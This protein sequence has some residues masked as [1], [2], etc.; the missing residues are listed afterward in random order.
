MA[1]GAAADVEHRA[2]RHSEIAV[3]R[4]PHHLAHG[5]V[6]KDELVEPR[7]VV[8]QASEVGGHARARP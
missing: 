1:P 8:E 2:W 5:V 7:L 6:G 4:A 3:E